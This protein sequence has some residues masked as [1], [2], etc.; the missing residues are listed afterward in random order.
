MEALA[1]N[2]YPQFDSDVSGEIEQLYSEVG[3]DGCGCHEV[4][5]CAFH[6]KLFRINHL[7]TVEISLISDGLSQIGRVL[8]DTVP[9]LAEIDEDFAKILG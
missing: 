3:D 1:S 7:Q 6:Q 8:S 2:L 9:L 4:D 5:P